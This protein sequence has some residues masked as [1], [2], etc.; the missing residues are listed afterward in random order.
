MIHTA[1]DLYRLLPAIYRVRD[2]KEK[3]GVLRALVGVLA[4]EAGIVESDIAK[5]YENWFIETCD[6]WVVP[7]IGD[8]L[9]VRGLHP[10]SAPT[11]SLRA[12]V[13]H[14]LGYR[15]RKGTAAMLEQLAHDSTGW[16]AHAV[17]FFE[18]LHWTQNDNHLRLKNLITPD[19]RRTAALELLD[20]PFDTIAHSAD[21]RHIASR[22][23]KHN[24]PNI[25]LFLWR[26]KAFPFNDPL[27]A[28]TARAGGA[29][30]NFR[31]TFNPLG[32]DA[33]LFNTLEPETDI[34]QLAEEINV[35]AALRRRPLYDEL[36]AHRQKIADNET[37]A[38]LYFGND[39]AFDIFIN[40]E[41]SPVKPEEILI[42]DLSD[43]RIPAP[44]KTYNATVALKI[45]AAVDPKLGRMTF[46]TA[47]QVTA[48]RV[49]YAYGFSGELGGGPYD[50]S[51]FLGA[52]LNRD[53]SS[54]V[55]D[56]VT[57]RV[58]VSQTHASIPNV[59]FSKLAD[60]I[61]A[62][63]ARPAGEIGCIAILDTRS[64]LD[65]LT[66]AHQIV[67]PDGS[68]LLIFAG[69]LVDG[70]P[71][72]EA[73]PNRQ[74]PH[75]GGL[76][77]VFGTAPANSQTPGELI[78]HGLLFEHGISV[79]DGNLGGL[80]LHH[81]TL[82]PPAGDLTVQTSNEDLRVRLLRSICGAIHLPA[83]VPRLEVEDSIVD[84]SGA[85]AIQAT[86]ARAD[87]EASTFVGQV[88]VRQL[89]AGDSIFFEKVTATIHQAG[90]VRFCFVPE[91]SNTPRRYRCQPELALQDVVDVVAQDSI[92][93]RIKPAFTSDEYGQ[94]GYGQLKL[95]VPEE[96]TTGADDGAEMGAFHFLQQPQREANLEAS[97]DEYL[98]FGLEAGIFFVS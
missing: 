46:P 77:D 70:A 37:A 49:N 76:V 55:M 38:T 41:T 14:T 4:R 65:D 93:G 23:G 61:D 44:L 10:V 45:R 36:E 78:L 20:T 15:R 48:A 53:E 35:P 22:R 82:A 85:P 21:V 13:A 54:P 71:L 52:L 63:N 75:L 6:E 89:E 24:L 32:L 66:G 39:R 88:H 40:A 34:T 16:P 28:V 64:Y 26:L 59:I 60:A 72:T 58:A 73:V 18:L 1:E 47:E 80:C 94:P 81:C 11:Y 29:A 84:G 90:C 19:L 43:W 9:G 96:I 57:W 8:L 69:D 50:R 83:S 79:L 3:N 17:E 2:E 42:C 87:L 62:W 56:G 30:P 92:R 5:L 7:Y 51:D 68:R 74:R 86:G 12:R 91:S 27:G 98:R 67:I 97:L 33:P 31:F 25:G 95:T